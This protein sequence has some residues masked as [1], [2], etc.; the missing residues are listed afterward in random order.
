M[1]KHLIL[2]GVFVCFFTPLIGQNNNYKYNT[3]NG[4][5]SNNIRRIIQDKYGFIWLA[6][7]EGLNRFDGKTFSKYSKNITGINSL[8][9]IDIW[10]IQEDTLNNLVWV[11]PGNGGINAINSKTGKIVNTISFINKDPDGWNTRFIK[12]NNDFWIA[13][14]NGLKNVNLQTGNLIDNIDLG[15][16]SSINNATHHI[17]KLIHAGEGEL[18]LFIDNF[19]VVVYN[20]LLKKSTAAI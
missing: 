9:G 5:I 6:T 12:V 20:Y 2:L 1:F 8:T 16:P 10:D 17:N 18:L 19:G 3:K 13:S 7:Q 15:L 4:L 14:Y 11:L